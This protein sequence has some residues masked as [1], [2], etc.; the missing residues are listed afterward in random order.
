MSR[1]N[2]IDE[3]ERTISLIDVLGLNVNY[4]DS[5]GNIAFWGTGKIP[6]YNKNINPYILLDGSSGNMEVD[7]FYDFSLNPHVINPENNFVA[8]ANNDPT[9]SGATYYPGYYLPVNRIDIINNELESQEMWDIEDVKELQ[10]NQYSERDFKLK[11]MI[12]D[13]I[14]DEINDDSYLRNG[15]ETLKNWN[16]EYD[17]DAKAPLIMSK[18]YYFINKNMMGDELPSDIFEYLSKSYLLSASVERLYSDNKSPWW[19]DINT[20]ETIETRKD[21]FKKSFVETLLQLKDEW[22]DD[23]NNWRWENAHQL[24]FPHFFSQQKLLAR[25]FDIGPFKMPSCQGCINKMEYPSD[26]SK[27]H[28]VNGGPAMRNIVDFSN[29]GNSLGKIPT[30]QSGCQGSKYYSDQ[31]PLFINGIYRNMYLKDTTITKN[32]NVLYLKPE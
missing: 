32:D 13:I 10:L 7:S 25:F 1:V 27:I 17:S 28:L 26:N 19:D 5:E 24:T 3:F 14:Q 2:N 18:L 8:T 15:F 22:G 31:T 11:S 29:Q 12:C 6:V 16:G 4:G 30:G 9:L 23:I 20:P 21:I